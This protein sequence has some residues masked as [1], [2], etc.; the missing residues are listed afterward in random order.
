MVEVMVTSS[1]KDDGNREKRVRRIRGEANSRN[2]IQATNTVSLHYATL[3]NKL[4]SVQ[5]LNDQVLSSSLLTKF[6]LSHTIDVTVVDS[7]A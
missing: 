4:T 5:D 1:K 6:R 3:I 7:L 2:V